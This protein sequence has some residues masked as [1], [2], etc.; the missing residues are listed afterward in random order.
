[1]LTVTSP[2]RPRSR[3]P[4]PVRPRRR[5]RLRDRIV[6]HRAQRR[7]RRGHHRVQRRH[8]GDRR[9]TSSCTSSGK[10]LVDAHHVGQRTRSQP[11]P[12]SA[13][14]ASSPRSQSLLPSRP[15][16]GASSPASTGDVTTTNGDVESVKVTANGNNAAVADTLII[17]GAL[18]SRVPARARSPRSTPAPT[19]KRGWAPPRSTQH[20]AIVVT[21][22]AAQRRHSDFRHRIGGLA[23]I[24]SR[25]PPPASAAPSGPSSPVTSRRVTPPPSPRPASTPPPPPRA[26]HDRAHRRRR[27]DRP[28]PDRGGASVE[29]HIG[30]EVGVARHRPTLHRRR[31]RAPSRSRPTPRVGHPDR[32][33][34]DIGGAQ[35]HADAAR[36]QCQRRDQGVRP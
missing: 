26:G 16:A 10:V 19:S 21:A 34:I 5:H 32:H 35:H 4:Q 36:G 6:G 8:R 25:C 24:S 12:R 20:G 17:N 29:A 11:T 1:M 23:A 14:A 33:S 7:G 28:R 2:I 22:T 15:I 31:Q 18:A 27:A 9:A 30:P 13:P 3:S